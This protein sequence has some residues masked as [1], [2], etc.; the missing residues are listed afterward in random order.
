M[1]VQQ[2]RRQQQRQHPEHRLLLQIA[3]LV[4][5][6]LHKLLA[7]FYFSLILQQRF[8]LQQLQRLQLITATA[9]VIVTAFHQARTV[10]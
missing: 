5:S 9:T 10:T 7:A 6:R 8:Q 3:V 2:R 1:T 4:E